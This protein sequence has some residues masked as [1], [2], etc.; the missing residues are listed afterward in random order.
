MDGTGDLTQG[1][2]GRYAARCGRLQRAAGKQSGERQ[3]GG[4]ESKSASGRAQNR[5]LHTGSSP[6]QIAVTENA[7]F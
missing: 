7:A 3:K 5:E 4:G 1:D 6:G 2:L